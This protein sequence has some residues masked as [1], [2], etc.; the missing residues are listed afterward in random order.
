MRNKE[1]QI[2]QTNYYKQEKLLENWKGVCEKLH[3]KIGSQSTGI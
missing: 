3:E 2:N 1:L